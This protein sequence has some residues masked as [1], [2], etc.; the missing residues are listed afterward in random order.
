MSLNLP[1]IDKGTYERSVGRSALGN[2][3]KHEVMNQGA[4][5]NMGSSHATSTG[6]PTVLSNLISR[7]PPH[8]GPEPSIDMFLRHLK[9]TTLP[10]RPLEEEE[11]DLTSNIGVKRAVPGAEW[12]SGMSAQSAEGGDDID[13]EMNEAAQTSRD[14]IFRQRQRARRG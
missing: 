12:L 1:D 13:Y 6:V 8:V 9:S 14:D 3:S 4:G 10:P 5:W 7:L 11:R 2:N